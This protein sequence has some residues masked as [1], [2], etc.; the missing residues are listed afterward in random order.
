MKIVAGDITIAQL[1]QM[2]GAIFG[3]LIKAVVD[4]DKNLL[5]VDA[6]LHSDLEAMLLEN[7]SKQENLWGINLYPDLKGDDFIEFDSVINI[8][9]SQN[10]NSRGV[11][12]ENI[13]K[14]IKAIVERKIQK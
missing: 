10:N 1:K 4:I 11:S 8:R 9:P 2:A 3:N 14:K 13:R 5:A 6:E 12:D 7:G